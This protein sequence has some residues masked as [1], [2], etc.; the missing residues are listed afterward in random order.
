MSE[1][2]PFK[3]SDFRPGRRIKR[4]KEPKVSLPSAKDLK[5]M[6]KKGRKPPRTAQHG[7]IKVYGTISPNYGRNVI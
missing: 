7:Y 5:R 4:I 3:G 1:P 6:R 2:S